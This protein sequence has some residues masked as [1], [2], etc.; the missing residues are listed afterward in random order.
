MKKISVLQSWRAIFIILICIEHMALTNKLAILG[1]GAEG[2]SFFIILSGFLTG[3]IYQNK[4]IDCS[5][6][7]S[8]EFLIKKLK[9]FY[10]LH[11]TAIILSVILQLLY[12]LKN[13][14][15]QIYMLLEVFIKAVLN[16]TFL[17]VYIPVDGWYMNNIH[18]VGW[19]LSTIVFCYANS[20]VG[21]KIIEKMQR[22]KK[23]NFLFV[24]T[25]LIYI[26][27]MIIFKDTNQSTFVLYVFPPYRYLEYFMAMMF[28]Y[29]YNHILGLL[30]VHNKN[31]WSILEIFAIIIL[32][33][34]HIIIKSGF[35]SD[36]GNYQYLAMFI[37]SL[38]IVIVFSMEKGVIS[39]ILTNKFLVSVGNASFY[40]Y[41]MHQV[42]I[43]YVTTFLGWNNIGALV[44]AIVIA[45]Y[46]VIIYKYYDKFT[47]KVLRKG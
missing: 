46:T 44:S 3:Y 31:I 10:P 42:I 34:N 17:Q 15:I 21:M 39:Q 27:I 23:D 25:L 5:F 2:V 29:N 13:Y 35:Y 41:I 28:G 22:K 47:E 37:C 14:G 4:E 43:K 33:M 11:L 26:V 38:L 40:I 9:K 12:L 20:L 1:A 30:K 45:V 16:A 32:V 8:K 18:G 7:K 6:I 24:I 19:F 36:N